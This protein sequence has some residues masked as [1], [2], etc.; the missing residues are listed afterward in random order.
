MLSERRILQPC[1]GVVGIV[2]SWNHFLLFSFHKVVR[3]VDRIPLPQT[4]IGSWTCHCPQDHAPWSRTLCLSKPIGPIT[5]SKMCLPTCESTAE[6]G[7]SIRYT[8]VFWY[9]ARATDTLCFCPPLRFIPCKCT[10]KQI[11][12]TPQLRF[13]PCK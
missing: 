7:S 5:L 4:P 1:L 13:I 12:S 3:K 11:D 2:S 6:S 10:K 8:S 9:T